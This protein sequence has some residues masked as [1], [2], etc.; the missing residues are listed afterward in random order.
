[1]PAPPFPPQSSSLSDAVP[2]VRPPHLPPEIVGREREF[3]LLVER[4]TAAAM[5]RGGLVLLSGEAGTG[6]TVCAELLAAH[7]RTQG[8]A[9]WSGGGHDLTETPPFGLWLDLFARVPDVTAMSGSP[10]AFVPFA[11]FMSFMPS[12]TATTG[13][14]PDPVT[15]PGALVAWARRTVAA[16][17]AGLLLVLDDLQWADPA[18]LDLLRFLA[19]AAVTMPLL[20]V[21]SYRTGELPAHTPLYDLL[22][23]LV[24]EAHATHVTLRPLRPTDVRVL[25]GV[26]YPLRPEDATRLSAHL[27]ERSGGNPFFLAELLYAFEEEGLLTAAGDGRWTLGDIAAAPVPPLLQQVIARRFGQVDEAARKL[28]EIAAVMGDE[29]PFDLWAAVADTDEDAILAAVEAAGARIM[30]E[31]ADG[32]RASFTHALVRAVLYESISPARR[33]RMHRRVADG[34]IAHV[35]GQ[36][37]PDT[38][39]HH[40]QQAG[41]PRALPWLL[42]AGERAQAA[43]AWLSAAQRFEAAL[44]LLE[45]GAEGAGAGE[46]GAGN[47]DGHFAPDSRLS[48]ADALPVAERGWLRFRLAMLRRYVNPARG[49][50]YLD[51]AAD[52]AAR[53]HDAP[54]AALTRFYRGHLHAFAGDFRQGLPELEAGMTALDAL[55][56]ADHARLV[57]RQAAIGYT[58]GTG[59]GTFALWLATVGRYVDARAALRS[60][61]DLA[62]DSFDTMHPDTFVALLHVDAALG[63]PDEAGTA[64]R[65]ARE[66]FAAADHWSQVTLAATLFLYVV[67]LPYGADD[68]PERERLATAAVDALARASGQVLDPLPPQVARLPLL[69]V[70]GEW[71]AIPALAAASAGRTG[72]NALIAAVIGAQLARAQG[73]GARAWR[74]VHDALPEG[75]DT[76]P[77]GARFPL[78]LAMV[79][80]GAAL[81]LDADDLPAAHAWSIAYDRW[82]AWSGA[83]RGQVEGAL[84]WAQF[85]WQAGDRAAAERHATDALAYAAT[86]RQPLALL[87]A[88]RLRGE[89]ATAGGDGKTADTHLR[90]ALALA[91]ACA[92]PYERA[93]TL[94]A[95]A[96]LHAATG[97]GTATSL[98]AEAR[99]IF[100]TLGARP[101]LARVVS[102]VAALDAGTD[103]ANVPRR[104]PTAS[105]SSPVEAAPD[106]LTLREREVLVSISTGMSN[107]EIA[108]TLSISERTVGR[109]ISNL[110]A[111]IGARGKADATIYALRHRLTP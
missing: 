1:M 18:S 14:I 72:Q 70:A 37:D 97:V 5:G 92:A 103:D 63:M 76:A 96:E 105:I 109:H 16:H 56:P 53:A 8:M 42:R 87:T 81:A 25:V 4:L 66:H 36:P 68:L 7:A 98:L 90:A 46:A 89:L 49:L 3:A 12:G 45:A 29:V 39:A 101:A 38:V 95:M 51:H 104:L 48:T 71:E 32:T 110:Y 9:V 69:F 17:P 102:L 15:L 88:H 30:T 64:F 83:V 59:R 34:L 67:A 2:D 93:L 47:G 20:I 58:L 35:P 75:S 41:D 82:L 91:D 13:A 85:H 80:E 79:R 50:A 23:A 73:D 21:A 28:L 100:Q 6:K 86:P 26:R 94:I 84:L 43:Y 54:L 11:P 22:P 24:R 44:A 19:R 10:D 78:A 40:L 55:S 62:T 77:G 60:A 99:G 65:A 57:A 31:R 111:K 27:T 33:R 106:G 52:D 108:A 61:A 107:R 74:L